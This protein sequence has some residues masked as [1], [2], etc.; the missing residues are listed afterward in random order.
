MAI[1]EAFEYPV[2]ERFFQAVK[3]YSSACSVVEREFDIKH[4]FHPQVRLFNLIQ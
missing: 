3:I 2:D 1:S 4:P